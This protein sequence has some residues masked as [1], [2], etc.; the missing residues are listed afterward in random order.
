MNK[1]KK[2]IEAFEGMIA[3]RMEATGE[4]RKEACDFIRAYIQGIQK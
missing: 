1:S 3:R 2:L 4:S